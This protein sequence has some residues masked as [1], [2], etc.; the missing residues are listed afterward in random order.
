VLLERVENANTEAVL[1]ATVA[2]DPDFVVD[3]VAQKTRI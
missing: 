3:A 1:K 2:S